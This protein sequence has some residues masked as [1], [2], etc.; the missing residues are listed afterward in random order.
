MC[1]RI[2]F[3]DSV[4]LI[5]VFLTTLKGM[6]NLFFKEVMEII[7]MHIFKKWKDKVKIYIFLFYAALLVLPDLGKIEM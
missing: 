6:S 3:L 5:I 2:W 4:L 1:F 7:L